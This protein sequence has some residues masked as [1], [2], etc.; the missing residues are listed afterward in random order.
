MDESSV[1]MMKF[2]SQLFLESHKKNNGS[3]HHQAVFKS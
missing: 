2:H 1:G 3:S